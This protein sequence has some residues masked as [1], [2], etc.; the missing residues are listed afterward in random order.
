M[1]RTIADMNVVGEYIPAAKDCEAVLIKIHTSDGVEI[2]VYIDVIDMDITLSTA[3]D[4][5]SSV[6]D[7]VP[8]PHP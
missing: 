3:I 2:A 8:L 6:T 5:K 7:I 4:N 1:P